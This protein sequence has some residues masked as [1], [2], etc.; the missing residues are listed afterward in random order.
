MLKSNYFKEQS[1]SGNKEEVKILA[2]NAKND[3]IVGVGQ[4]NL[5]ATSSRT[6]TKFTVSSILSGFDYRKIIMF[7]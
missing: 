6:D 2:V 4:R 1:W 7:I 3:E 5:M